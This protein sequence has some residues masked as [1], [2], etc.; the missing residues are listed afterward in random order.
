MYF[1]D[2]LDVTDC[3]TRLRDTVV[4]NK[5]TE[6]NLSVYLLVVINPPRDDTTFPEECHALVLGI[7]S[8]ALYLSNAL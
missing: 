7:Q 5:T 4:F 1:W 2:E 8:C 6:A 3:K